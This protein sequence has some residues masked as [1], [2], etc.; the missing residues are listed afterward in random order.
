MTA[1]HLE[2]STQTLHIS[3]QRISV[4]R[5]RER[6]RERETSINFFLGKPTAPPISSPIFSF[7]LPW[8]SKKSY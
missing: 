4:Q 5:E 8:R 6:E 3:S 7:S 2:P 1:V